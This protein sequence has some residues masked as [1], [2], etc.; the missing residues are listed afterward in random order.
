MG[1][2]ERCHCRFWGRPYSLAKPGRLGPLEQVGPP[3]RFPAQLEQPQRFPAQLGQ[4]EQ[5]QRF[6]AQLEQL[7]LWG[8]LQPFLDR[9][10]REVKAS[11]VQR[12]PKANQG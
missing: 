7:G 10:V 5:P 1:H 2:T 4:R 6:L 8:Q 9:Q 12:V 11:Q 3:R